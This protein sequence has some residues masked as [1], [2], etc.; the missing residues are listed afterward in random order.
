MGEEE[1]NG[2][3]WDGTDGTGRTVTS[4]VG[5]APHQCDPQPWGQRE[6]DRAVGAERCGA[7]SRHLGP[8]ETTQR[9]FY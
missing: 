3:G 6:A 4:A 2:M 7:P 8:A 5:F 9:L 1:G